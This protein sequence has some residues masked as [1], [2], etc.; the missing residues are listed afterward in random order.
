MGRHLF[1]P[2]GMAQR[3]ISIGLV[4]LRSHF[5]HCFRVL[6]QVVYNR[7]KSDCS[8]IGSCKHV[9]AEI[10]HNVARRH[11]QLVIRLDVVPATEHIGA[12]LRIIIQ[13]SV[14]LELGAGVNRFESKDKHRV[15][16]LHGGGELRQHR[17]SQQDVVP[18]EDGSANSSLIAEHFVVLP[19]GDLAED[20]RVCQDPLDIF[21]HSIN[22]L[23]A[24]EKA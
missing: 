22:I 11:L 14:A 1:V 4:N 10:D 23:S 13:L 20:G 9:G 21:H 2:D 17:I 18:S 7:A 6:A 24:F 16:L 5:G 8:R 15:P 19:P 12:F 3:S